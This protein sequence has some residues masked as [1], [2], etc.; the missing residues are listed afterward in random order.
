MA[1]LFCDSFDHY[2]DTGETATN[3]EGFEQKWDSAT[4]EPNIVVGRTGNAA[5]FS[6][7]EVLGKAVATADT[8]S[9]T[10]FTGFA[11]KRDT[12]TVTNACEFLNFTTGASI[13]Q[14]A[15]ALSDE[16]NRLQVRTG[17]SGA[18]LLSE[19]N[20]TFDFIGGYHYVEFSAKVHNTTGTFQVKV[21]GVAP[22]MTTNN[23]GVTTFNTGTSTGMSRMEWGMSGNMN[24][25]YIDDLYILNDVAVTNSV[26]N[27]FL[28]DVKVVCTF[29]IL[30]GN[31]EQWTRSAT[32]G[33]SNSDSARLVDDP[34][35]SSPC[36]DG[37]ATYISSTTNGQRSSF[38]CDDITTIGAPKAVQVIASM[39]T[40]TNTRT[41][42]VFL[43]TSAT[44]FDGAGM[45]IGASAYS[46]LNNPGLTDGRRK[47]WDVNPN[48]NTA[49]TLDVLNNSEIG[50]L[51]IS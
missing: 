35:A 37:D 27:T 2:V 10:F 38:I 30:D 50:V 15:L 13:N 41:G 11:F 36:P 31:H 5:R 43:R 12:G 40:D 7:S 45:L 14:I 3:P 16:N 25:M 32:T 34:P 8:N 33:N 6:A 29:P 24:P 18:T 4:T 28:G 1:L 46:M 42:A 23:D 17:T 20:A 9:V 48:G 21:D 19:T 22:A 26:T 44:D 49:W 47:V 51:V 39:R